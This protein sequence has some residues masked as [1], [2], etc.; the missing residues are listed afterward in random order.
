MKVLIT[1]L[2]VLAVFVVIGLFLIFSGV[3]NISTY[4]HDFGLMNRALD[5]AMTHSVENHA[6][7]IQAPNLDD[8]EMVRLGAGHYHDN[9]VGCHGAPGVKPGEISEGLWPE[10]PNL[11][12]EVLPWT[13]SQAFWLVKYGIKFTAM[14]A[15][16][17]SHSDAELWA[18]VAFL[19]RIHGMSASEYQSLIHTEGPGGAEET[20]SQPSALK[21]STGEQAPGQG[22]SNHD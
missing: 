12:D 20:S 8:P 17:P 3:Y 21:E 22:D 18:I 7:G 9:C 10:P 2:V 4:N 14:P 15:W 13:P 5:T 11:T 16:G 19:E 1:V 6:E